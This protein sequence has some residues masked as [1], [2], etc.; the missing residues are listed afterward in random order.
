MIASA[1]VHCS[2]H[3]S[4]SKSNSQ[5]PPNPLFHCL[6]PDVP[7]TSWSRTGSKLT[8]QWCAVKSQLA[9]NC[10]FKTKWLIISWC[11]FRN[12]EKKETGSV[13]SRYSVNNT[14]YIA[15]LH[16]YIPILTVLVLQLIDKLHFQT[17]Q[18]LRYVLTIWQQTSSSP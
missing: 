16:H 4:F 2:F 3:V 5:L 8:T 14:N 18:Y 11:K 12:R 7:I 15:K 10:P 6:W 17:N 13:R 9:E 1:S